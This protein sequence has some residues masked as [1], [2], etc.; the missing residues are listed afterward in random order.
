MPI[1]F[2]F[3]S[4]SQHARSAPSLGMEPDTDTWKQFASARSRDAN[5]IGS[6]LVKHGQRAL[7]AAFGTGEYELTKLIQ[8]PPHNVTHR[9]P[10][11]GMSVGWHRFVSR[12]WTRTIRPAEAETRAVAEARD[13]HQE[14]HQLLYEAIHARPDL[15]EDE[16]IHRL[17]T[18][19]ADE[20]YLADAIN[21]PGMGG[22]HYEALVQSV[23][24]YVQGRSDWGGYPV[25]RIVQSSEMSEQTIRNQNSHGADTSRDKTRE[26]TTNNIW[27]PKAPPRKS[28][29]AAQAAV[30]RGE[31]EEDVTL[32]L[33]P[34]PKLVEDQTEEAESEGRKTGT[35]HETTHETRKVNKFVFVPDYAKIRRDIRK[36]YAVP[37]YV[38]LDTTSLHVLAPALPL[39]LN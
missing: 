13:A 11:D 22:L 38:G 32:D 21:R 2:R 19:P 15:W 9:R 18:L 31:P 28:R 35:K 33:E 10:L 6:N 30:E 39:K 16:F 29:K 23:G 1:M 24:M 4:I 14:W 25:R 27:R 12:V 26:K 34:R 36:L 8:S 3:T 7:E 20:L 17:E 37:D 5:T